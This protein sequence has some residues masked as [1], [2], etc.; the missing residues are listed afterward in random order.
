MAFLSSEHVMAEATNGKGEQKSLLQIKNVVLQKCHS[1]LSAFVEKIA[2]SNTK[3]ELFKG[4]ASSDEPADYE[5]CNEVY[6]RR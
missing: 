1:L 5:Y 6:A 2:I 3:V 4:E